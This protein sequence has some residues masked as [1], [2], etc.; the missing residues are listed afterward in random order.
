MGPFADGW[1]EVPDSALEPLGIK[2]LAVPIP[3]LEAGGPVNV[4]AIRDG[5]DRWA[6][7]DCGLGTTEALSSLERSAEAAGVDLTK[8]S[9]LFVSHGHID[10]YGNAQTL[11]E[12]SGATVHIHPFDQEKIA[13]DAR[14][15]T[16]IR[17][18]SEFFVRLGVPPAV[19]ESLADSAIDSSKWARRVDASRVKPL[20]DGMRLEFEAFSAEVLHTPGH[21]PG[22]VCLWASGPRVLF[23]DDHILARVSPNPLIDLS[24]GSGEKKFRALEAY[25]ASARRVMALDVD[26]VL[27]GH[28]PLFRG[29][30]AL[31]DSLFAFYGRRQ[32]RLF[33]RLARE[34]ASVYDLVDTLYPNASINRLFLMLSEVLGNVEVL[35]SSGRIRRR[36][37]GRYAISGAAMSYSGAPSTAQ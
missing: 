20:A 8:L 36:D 32:E 24:F 14:W 1:G 11:A 35:E 5:H 26:V 30:R 33:D 34:P 15:S 6:L 10:H 29:H 7:F 27:P 13:G 28:G 12:R 3:F 22:L 17:R 37:D 2:R 19:L 25:F 31:L 21:T 4:Y 16:L 18:E 23:A 9:R